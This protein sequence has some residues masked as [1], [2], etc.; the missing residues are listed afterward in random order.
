M[1]QQSRRIGLFVMTTSL[2]ASSVS[3]Q[4][5]HSLHQYGER[6]MRSSVNLTIPLGGQR[7]DATSKPQLTMSFQQHRLQQDPYNFSPSNIDV[8]S[9]TYNLQPRQARIGFTLDQNPELM[10]N[11][12][13]YNLPTNTANASTLGKVGIGAAV[14]VGIGV[15]VVGTGLIIIASSGGSGSD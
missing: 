3:A 14:L 13:P 5:V 10:M 7:N 11:G 8:K 12:R 15:L 1:I 4:S 2:V 6:D 9:S